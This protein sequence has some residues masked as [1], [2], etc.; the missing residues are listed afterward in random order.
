[1]SVASTQVQT[2]FVTSLVE[3]ASSLFHRRP[4]GFSLLSLVFDN[5]SGGLVNSD[6]MEGMTT[7]AS[8]SLSTQRARTNKLRWLFW[9]HAL[10]WMVVV[11]LCG[12]LPMP[13]RRAQG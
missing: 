12:R 4:L 1:M 5:P 7:P 8:M 13:H 11:A 2:P 3:T 6:T 9:M 10:V